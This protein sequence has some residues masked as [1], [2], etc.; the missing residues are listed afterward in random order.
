MV[1]A[2]G[3]AT[4]AFAGSYSP[5]INVPISVATYYKEN[6]INAAADGVASI[7]N[8]APVAFPDLSAT[9]IDL[10]STFN[11]VISEIIMWSDDIEDAGIEETSA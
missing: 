9:D 4:Q 8:T 2:G 3:V 1:V 11:G 6:G 10:A 5:G 7:E